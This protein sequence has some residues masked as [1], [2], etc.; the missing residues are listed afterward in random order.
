MVEIKDEDIPL[1]YAT[2]AVL[3]PTAY[4]SKY[5]Q[6][7]FKDKKCR[8]CGNIFTPLAPSHHYCSYKC[9]CESAAEN[10]LNSTYGITLEEYRAIYR[11]QE[12]KCAICK[13]EGFTLQDDIKT[14]LV[15]D[16]HHLSGGVRGLLCHNCNRAIGLFKDDVNLFKEAIAYIQK[17]SLESSYIVPK[18]G[19]YNNVPLSKEQVFALY[20]D[21][22]VL[23][24]RTKEITEKYNITAN[25]KAN[26]ENGKSYKEY[27]QEYRERATTIPKGSRT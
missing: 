6:G 9:G 4:P 27:L 19:N 14:P 24:L 21:I 10:Y 7:Y 1:P 20:D 5:P 15:L 3:N 16:H 11:K 12:G 2:K 17:P 13:K 8:K 26:I 18:R 25:T 22:F 23:K